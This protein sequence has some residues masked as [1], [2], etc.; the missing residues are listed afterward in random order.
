M[1]WTVVQTWS[2]TG[3]G[4]S[5]S[6]SGSVTTNGNTLVAALVTTVATEIT[7]PAGWIPFTG[8]TYDYLDVGAI[9]TYL[10]F[11]P[12]AAATTLVSFGLSASS[13]SLLLIAE[14]SNGGMTASLDG[15]EV[16]TYH[17]PTVYTTGTITTT[18]A[19]DAVL[20]LFASDSG[21]VGWGDPTNGFSVLAQ[22]SIGT[23]HGGL[24][25][26]L[27][28]LLNVTP[29]SYS[30]SLTDIGSGDPTVYVQILMALSPSG[31]GGGLVPWPLFNNRGI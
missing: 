24:S 1:S 5:V 31:T 16:V 15:S 18:A 22:T 9:P 28:G 20:A 25:L 12:G 2:G 7:F 4:T 6:A 27:S 10:G 30:T 26:G 17:A 13:T 8:S 3:T 14:L 19:S 23:R 11:L 21:T 29:G